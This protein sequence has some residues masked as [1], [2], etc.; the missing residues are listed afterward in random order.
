[1]VCNDLRRVARRYEALKLEVFFS[2]GA[3]VPAVSVCNGLGSEFVVIE[4]RA[5][6]ERGLK[7]RV[8]T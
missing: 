2:G 6:V 5:Q 3:Q 1:M 8:L 4:L 7:A